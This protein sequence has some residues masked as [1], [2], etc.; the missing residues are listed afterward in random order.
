GETNDIHPQDKKTVGDRLALAAMKVSYGQQIIASG[1]VY[2]SAR[3]EGNK[4]IIHF[5]NIGS[6]IVAKGK[7]LKYF[8]IAGENKK[9]V[10]AKAKM[11]T[12]KVIVGEAVMAY[13]V[14]VEDAWANNPS[15][16]K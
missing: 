3:V 13:Q 12:S 16:T 2:D 15:G 4:I 8:T 9:F 10:W 5:K 7:E 6:G 11:E 1:P 14:A